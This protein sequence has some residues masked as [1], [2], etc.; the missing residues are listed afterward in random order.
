[1]RERGDSPMRDAFI[2]DA[3]RTPIGRYGGGLSKVRTDDLAAVPIRALAKRHPE[4]DWAALDEVVLGCANQAGE[5]NRNVAR[6]A[7]LLAGLPDS[8]PGV[9]VNRLCASGLN[10]VG[11]AARAVRSGEIDFAI[12]GGVESMT[13]AP[14]VMGKAAEAFQRST[15]VYDTTIGWRF[16]NPLMKAQYGVDAMG[17]T[18]ENVAEEFQ[19]SRADQDAFAIR[20]QQRAGQAI[21]SGYFAAEIT[22]ISIPGGKAGPITVDRDEHPR[23]D[24][25][26]EGL[27]KLKPIVRNPGTVTAGNASGVNDGAAAMILA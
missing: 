3:V 5:D 18:G 19:V 12:A 15:E 24:T 2:C 17:E 16:I 26:M 8:V 7:L 13:R 27:A 10:A 23:P 22:P 9:T 20:S 6:M 21:A 11:E 4:I 14:L 25:T 1:M